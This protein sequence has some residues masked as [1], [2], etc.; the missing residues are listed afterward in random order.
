MLPQKMQSESDRKAEVMLERLEQKLH[1]GS[2]Q[3]KKRAASAAVTHTIP[4][5]GINQDLHSQSTQDSQ[6][7]WANVTRAEIQKAAEWATISNRKKKPLDHRRILFVRNR[8]PHCCNPRDIMFEVN[9]A[10]AHS[11]AD[12]TV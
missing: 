8:Q 11:R 5:S 2:E 1:E 4:G 9:K 6:R 10:L 3:A 7:T 12:V